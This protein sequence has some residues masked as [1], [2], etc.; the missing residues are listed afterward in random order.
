[1]HF[2]KAFDVSPCRIAQHIQKSHTQSDMCYPTLERSEK[3][4]H[5][6]RILWF[7]LC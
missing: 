1:M 6:S 5:I 7:P 2:T 3:S 4:S